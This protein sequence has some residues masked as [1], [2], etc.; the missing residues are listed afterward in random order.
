M[1]TFLVPCDGSDNALRALGHAVAEAKAES[2]PVQVDLLHVA[3]PDTALAASDSPSLVDTFADGD[4]VARPAAPTQQAM[5]AA[6]DILDQAGVPHALHWRIGDPA[7][8]IA[9]QACETGCDEIIMGTRGR[10]A[11]ASL[12]LGSVAAKVVQLAHV[13]VTLV[14]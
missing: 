2:V 4:P 7:T 8:E 5:Q 9:A 11:L 3:E 1:K 10:R 12:L 13:P 6:V 14:R